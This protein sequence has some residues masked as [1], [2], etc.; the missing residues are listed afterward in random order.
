[1]MTGLE[2]SHDSG[3]LAFED[4]P[5]SGVQAYGNGNMSPALSSLE[6]RSASHSGMI[7][8]G[9]GLDSHGHVPKTTAE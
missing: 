1:M 4:N 9:L 7:D 2:V 6:P 8:L 3:I 5:A